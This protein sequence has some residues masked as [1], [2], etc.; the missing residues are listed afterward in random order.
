[1]ISIEL[2]NGSNG[3]EAGSGFAVERVAG[4]GAWLGSW[5]A[6]VRPLFVSSSSPVTAVITKRPGSNSVPMQRSPLA[7]L[8]PR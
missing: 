5:A 4:A 7:A 3:R 1:M 2:W 8:P 6:M